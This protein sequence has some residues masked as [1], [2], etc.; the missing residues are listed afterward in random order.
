MVMDAG[1]CVP[2]TN[3]PCR[4]GDASGGRQD[5]GTLRRGAKPSETKPCS[6]LIK[7]GK[8][9]VRPEGDDSDFKVLFKRLAAA[10]AGRPV[11]EDGFPRGPWMPDLLAEAISQFEAN[12]A[13]VDLRTVQFWF[14]DNERGISA[15]NIRWL[16]RVFGCDDPEA[17]SAWQAELSASQMRLTAKRRGARRTKARGG[18]EALDAQRPVADTVASQSNA[19]G[20][21]VVAQERNQFSLARTSQALFS[22]TSPL[23]LP[24]SVFAGAVALQFVSYFLGIHSVTYTRADGVTKQVGLLWAPN[25]TFLFMVF[26]PLFL[27]FV[28]EILAFW[29][30]E[31]RPGLLA[32]AGGGERTDSWEKKVE[33]SAYT[34]WAVL[35][36]CV[37][38]AGL[39]Q[40]INVEVFPAAQRRWGLCD[41]LG[42]AGDRAA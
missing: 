16:A 30:Q 33:A 32:N 23:D 26:L 7:N 37:G 22:R 40:W 21:P 2:A 6:A 4:N 14:Q 3:R 41:R 35:L 5:H 12:R 8:Y 31:G 34:Y 19:L 28:A 17:T 1:D 27:T 38:F 9:F 29:K 42:F 20:Q 18:S 24:A 13:G 11:D 10:G 36:I 25:W 39:F 15:D